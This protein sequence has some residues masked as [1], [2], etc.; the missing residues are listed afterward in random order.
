MCALVGYIATGRTDP[1]PTLVPTQTA[2]LTLVGNTQSWIGDRTRQ[3][4]TSVVVPIPTISSTVLPTT[5]SELGLTL[6]NIPGSL[7]A[8]EPTHPQVSQLS[9]PD[10]PTSSPCPEHQVR[11]A[12][13]GLISRPIQDVLAINPDS[14]SPSTPST[15]VAS[16]SKAN[17][18]V[19]AIFSGSNEKGKA[20]ETVEDVLYDLSLQ[21]ASSV[22][23]ALDMDLIR[24]LADSFN[25]EVSEILTFIDQLVQEIKS[26]SVNFLEDPKRAVKK[27]KRQ[28]T[29]GNKQAKKNAKV[30][31][32]VGERF[33]GAVVN[34]LETAASTSTPHATEEGEAK[35]TGR[36]TKGSRAKEMA[37]KMHKKVFKSEEWLKHQRTV[38]ER[39]AG[40]VQAH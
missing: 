3:S 32:E 36:S 9:S 22:S 17:T 12:D 18:K 30:I 35:K 39:R 26:H 29:R 14:H 11:D 15:S 27:L 13:Q 1:S 40:A 8:V 7:L 5:N 34:N 19:H 6:V 25:R 16:T 33:L 38:A 31:A 24:V 2:T 4:A 37:L 21:L 28:L 20:R 23:Q 10:S